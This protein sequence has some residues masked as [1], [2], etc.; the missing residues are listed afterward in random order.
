MVEMFFQQNCHLDQSYL[1]ICSSVCISLKI[2]IS[3]IIFNASSRCITIVKSYGQ[4][5]YFV[6]FFLQVRKQKIQQ[7]ISPKEQGDPTIFV[8]KNSIKSSN[9]KAPKHQDI[10]MVNF[11]LVQ[12]GEKLTCRISVFKLFLEGPYNCSS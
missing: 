3:T 10:P 11:L 8:S 5:H 7:K 12:F 4:L 9:K 1:S 2:F 6:S